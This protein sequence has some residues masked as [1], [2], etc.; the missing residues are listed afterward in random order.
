M[1]SQ[2]RR[3][4]A[5]QRIKFL[6]STSF[7][8][9]VLLCSA[10][11]GIPAPQP[12]QGDPTVFHRALAQIEHD[13]RAYQGELKTTLWRGDERVRGRQL[14]LIAPPDRLR[15]TLLSPFEQPI[16]DLVY[17][18]QKLFLWFM[19]ENRF[20]SGT[21]SARAFARLTQVEISP[22]LFSGLLRGAPPRV[23]TDGG[24]V[25]WDGERGRYLFTLSAGDQRQEFALSADLSTLH[26]VQFWADGALRY[27]LSLADHRDGHAHRMRIEHPEAELRLDLRV[28]DLSPLEEV[29][30]DLFELSP[31]SGINVEPL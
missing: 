26:Q 31:P 15:L 25:R 9:I 20:F 6:T 30:P 4:Y 1:S 3:R 7:T 2:R 16:S 5:I 19:K 10:C 18:E 11:G 14:F 17:R 13:Q 27:R 28:V 23:K 24:S 22:A 8:V 21:A 29:T 12:F